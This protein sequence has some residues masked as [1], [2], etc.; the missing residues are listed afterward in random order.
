[1]E[2]ETLEIIKNNLTAEKEKLENELKGFTHKDE[3]INDNFKS[4]WPEYG[5]SDEE[6]AAEVSEYGD[7]LSIEHTLEEQLRDVKTALANIEAGKYGICKYCGNPIE[8]KRLLA[9]PASSSCVECKKKL[10]G[11]A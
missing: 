9:R 7:R 11:E 4:D 8:E 10:K 2:K 3:A 6:N 5:S 1:M